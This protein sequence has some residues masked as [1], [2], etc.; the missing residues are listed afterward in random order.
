MSAQG[1]S[2]REPVHGVLLLDKPRGCTSQ[3]ALQQARRALGAAKAGHTGTLDPLADGLL[4][5]CFGAATKFAQMHLDADKAYRAQVHLGISTSTCDGEGEVTQR[6]PV[7][8]LHAGLLRQ[9]L[10]GFIG[11]VQQVPP[12]H[13]ALKRDG[14]PLYEYARAGQDIELAPRQVRI[15]A[16]DV[17]DLRDDMLLIDVRCGKGT[18]IRSLARD[19]G[20]ALGCGAHLAGLRRTRSGGFELSQAR[21]LEQVGQAGVDHA[22]GWLL[23]PDSLVRELPE[24]R[25]E[26]HEAAAM[27][28]GRALDLPAARAPQ[29]AGALR[30]YGAPLAG[31]A[32]LFLGV[33]RWDGHELS[34]QRLL[35]SEELLTQTQTP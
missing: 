28:H 5:L 15:D 25:L 1:R 6:R 14:R 11:V 27:L 10:D 29:H 9:V 33:A 24:L 4:P 13:S 19:I 32:P 23:P 26:D 22:R 3:Q 8:A 30:I 20:D 2:R 7:P 35:S 12:M 34:V 17:V 18:Y 31:A 16:I 21:P